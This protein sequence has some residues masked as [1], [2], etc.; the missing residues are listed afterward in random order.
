MTVTT[1][2]EH[3]VYSMTIINSSPC[4]T[5]ERIQ[6]KNKKKNKKYS[7][8]EEPWITRDRIRCKTVVVAKEKG[9]KKRQALKWGRE[10][11]I[12]GWRRR[13]N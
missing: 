8:H 3:K 13:K 12:S 2:A 7:E 11:F 9:G 10:I 1:I 6:M 4:V 5:V